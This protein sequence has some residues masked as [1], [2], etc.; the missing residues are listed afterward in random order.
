MHTPTQSPKP[1]NNRALSTVPKPTPPTQSTARVGQGHQNIFSS[2]HCP[3]PSSTHKA[4]K[5]PHGVWTTHIEGRYRAISVHSLA[6][7]WWCFDAGHITKRQLRIW[8]AA[9]EM[10]ERRRY[11]AKPEHS[12]EAPRRPSYG[13]D[14]IKALIGGRGSKTADTAIKADLKRLH[15][16]GL[17]SITERSITFATSIDQLALNGSTDDLSSFWTMFNQLPHPRRRV[18]VPRRV[19]RAL[20]GGFTSGMTAVVLATLIRSLFWHKNTM[21]GNTGSGKRR[22][23]GVTGRETGAEEG[24]YRIDGRTKREWIAE[25]F[26][27]SAR[28]V[29]DARARLI[30]LGW[31]IPLETHQ[32]LLNRYGTHDQINTDWKPSASPQTTPSIESGG[33]AEGVNNTKITTNRAGESST[34]STDFSGGSSSLINRSSSPTGNLNTRR[35]APT[36]AGTTGASLRVA[37]K[38]K[39]ESKS[40]SKNKA[41]SRKKKWD[42]EKRTLGLPNI[43]DIRSQDLADTGRLLELHRQAVKAGMA[44][45][46][47][48]GRLDFVA[49]AQRARM[50]GRKSGALFFWLLREKKTK[51]ITHAT[52]EEAGRMIKEHLY[53]KQVHQRESQQWGSGHQKTPMQP[54]NF[55]KEDQFVIACIRVAKKHRIAD[56]F[57]LAREDGWTRDRWNTVLTSYEAKQF[58]QL[59]QSRGGKKADE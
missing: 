20:A 23:G 39:N 21:A 5:F 59:Q 53:G 30:E 11:T 27:I 42:G 6:M 14:E 37:L 28:T 40:Q 33:G 34:P 15:T 17:V 44:N 24:V 10:L 31:L 16:L 9:Q 7:A 1:L 13:L 3:K 47:E 55:T 50:S 4:P 26:G 51:F 49:L 45:P 43:R 38:T 22:S 36:R 35:P 29:T 32:H 58:E 2:S 48:A 41:G 19:L 12:R 54:T 56:P 25:I 52:E 18:P 46:S 8:F 57:K